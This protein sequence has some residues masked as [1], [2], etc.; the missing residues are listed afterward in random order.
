VIQ[1]GGTSFGWLE[2]QRNQTVSRSINFGQNVRG[3]LY[4]PSNVA[5]NTK[6]PTVIWLH[7]YSYSLGYMWGYHSDLH[8]ILAL[9]QAGYAVLAYDQSGFGSRMGESAP[10]YDRYPHWSQMGRM[11]EDARAAIDA[12]QKDD[13]AD[14]Q[15]DFRFWIFA[16]RNRGT[17][18]G[19]AG[20][21][22]QLGGLDQRL[23]AMRTD[24]ADRGT[25]GVAR[26]RHER[27]LIPRL[28]FLRGTNIGSRLISMNS[29]R[30]L[31]RR[32]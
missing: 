23:H 10:I 12:L 28:G 4:Y 30:Q 3:D 17:L 15:T 9:V 1:R 21:A 25:G 2:P 31:R 26:Y 11:V 5:P 18:Y 14:P 19:C 32:R 16:G 6:P 20:F 22:G 7:S 13:L 8:P 29:S 24:T 27:G